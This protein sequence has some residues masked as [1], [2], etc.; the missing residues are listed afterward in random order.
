MDL[1]CPARQSIIEHLDKRVADEADYKDNHC[2]SKYF[3]GIKLS[4]VALRQRAEVFTAAAL[5]RDCDK[6][7]L[8]RSKSPGWR[9]S[10][11]RPLSSTGK[12]PGF[13]S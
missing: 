5:K 12:A 7:T 3:G 4:A 10:K 9:I 6:D 1:A 13:S 8:E 11:S 2:N